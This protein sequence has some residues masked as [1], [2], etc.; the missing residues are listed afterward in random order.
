M[1]SSRTR[2][3]SS[4]GISILRADFFA[5]SAS[6]EGGE[7]VANRTWSPN[8]A[9]CEDSEEVAS[10]HWSPQVLTGRVED[11][12][13]DPVTML[14]SKYDQHDDVQRHENNWSSF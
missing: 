4:Q 10:R 11:R 14:I 12:L 3:F 2:A 1:F 7:G 6:S 5:N 9:G 8:S 13:T